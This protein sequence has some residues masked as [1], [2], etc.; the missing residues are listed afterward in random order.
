MIDDSFEREAVPTSVVEPG[1]APLRETSG[2]I[3]IREYPD[4]GDSAPAVILDTPKPI[5]DEPSGPI[6]LDRR[7]PSE[8]TPPL[9]RANAVVM[10]GPRTIGDRRT[11]VGV[12]AAGT[13]RLARDTAVED[14]PAMLEDE[15]TREVNASGSLDS[16]PTRLELRAAPPSDEISSDD[17]LA[18][19]PSP[20]RDDD[21][22]PVVSPPAPRA[23][24]AASGQ[25]RL[26]GVIPRAGA[27]TTTRTTRRSCRASGTR[28]W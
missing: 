11:S 12:G 16:D 14:P 8:Q 25:I 18:A 10:K 1:T 7:R 5:E 4:A 15:V 20:L 28:R 2:E 17:H 3:V 26:S 24:P 9:E 27:R 6:L 21:T 23:S 19:P 22:S 13:K